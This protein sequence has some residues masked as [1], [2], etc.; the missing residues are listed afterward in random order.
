MEWGDRPRRQ[1]EDPRASGTGPS[2]RPGRGLAWGF[3]SPRY[4]SVTIT[5]MRGVRG[6]PWAHVDTCPR[7]R[8][9]KC[10]ILAGSRA[11]PRG[12]KVGYDAVPRPRRKPIP[13]LPPLQLSLS[14]SS[15]PPAG[16][17]GQF[18]MAFLP[19][20]VAARLL[21]PGML[22]SLKQKLSLAVSPVPVKSLRP[23]GPRLLPAW[24]CP[25]YSWPFRDG[26][27]GVN[28]A[29]WPKRYKHT[30]EV[31]IKKKK[32]KKIFK[33][34]CKGNLLLFRETKQTT[35]TDQRTF[36][37]VLQMGGCTWAMKHAHTCQWPAR[38][39]ELGTAL[40]QGETCTQNDRSRS[41]F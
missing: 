38:D 6:Q 26:F 31:K 8:S 27:T 24:P 12:G 17:L 18:V 1:T 41:N 2:C 19:P 29:T 23:S 16:S 4:T 35:R 36:P 10:T 28:E 22:W 15:W 13:S 40:R 34:L 14:A 9:C 33:R 3:C 32:L 11:G 21:F 7:N 5:G 37:K 30:L 39:P 25:R 20:A